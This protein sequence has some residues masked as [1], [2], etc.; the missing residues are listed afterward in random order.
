MILIDALYI[1]NGGGKILL[2]YLMEEL[3]KTDLQVT[4]LLDERI[5]NNHISPK[6][7]DE[8]IIMKASFL[9]R[10]KFYRKSRDK[11]LKILCFGNIPPNIKTSATV[12]TYFH[13]LLFLAIPDNIRGVRRIL[14]HLKIRV[15]NSLKNNTDYWMVQSGMTGSQLSDKYKLDKNKVLIVPFYPPIEGN[16]NGVTRKKNSF[17]YIS[18]GE[19]HKNHVRLINAFCSFYQKHKVGEL[20]VTISSDYTEEIQLI[21]KAGEEGYPIH[22]IGFVKREKLKELYQETEYLIFPS[23]A[24]SFGLGIVEAINEDCK[25]IGADLPYMHA[26]CDPSLIFDPYQ[27]KEIESAF[28]NAVFEKT[29][30]SKSLVANEINDL[31]NLLK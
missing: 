30:P 1:N 20:T 26:V 18:S 16:V 10:G 4:Y 6:S 21:K 7:S 28:E 11:F 29:K 31:I 19:K 9:S 3:N 25:V 14:Y 22:N 8:V 13:Q 15:L 2:D 5:R 17:V 23:L 24:E 12:F 27:V